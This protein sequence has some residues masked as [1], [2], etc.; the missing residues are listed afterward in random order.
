MVCDPYFIHFFLATNSP[1][2]RL[3][4]F[5]LKL[6]QSLYSIIP[7]P[8]F[9]F[10]SLVTS[11]LICPLNDD[12]PNLEP[13][14]VLF[15]T[16]IFWLLYIVSEF[17]L[18]PTQLTPKLYIICSLSFRFPIDLTILAYLN[19]IFATSEFNIGLA[20]R[21]V[22]FFH[23]MLWENPNNL[24]VN[25]ISPLNLLSLLHRYYASWWPVHWPTFKTQA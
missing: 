20:K 18:S 22:W 17:Q 7:V 16:T 23:E 14:P 6:L 3:P 19:D 4:P 8:D 5:Y 13:W 25:P 11:F 21:F 12:T 1:L 24:L 10:S 15:Y 9:S 2:C